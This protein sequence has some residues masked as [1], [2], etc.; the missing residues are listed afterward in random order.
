MSLRAELV[1]DPARLAP[2]LAAWDELAV[3]AG[4]PYCAPAW[5]LA[6]WRALVPA[7]SELRVVLA[8]DV[9]VVRG[10]ALHEARGAR[11][12][13]ERRAEVGEPALERRAV[14]HGRRCH[15]APAE[16]DTRA[17]T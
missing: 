2:H 6:W 11:V 10:V 8:L 5:M 7:G 9:A 16:T 17:A 4:R 14:R 1:D 12:A 13:G 15:A 3:A